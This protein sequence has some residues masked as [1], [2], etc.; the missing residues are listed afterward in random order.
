ML[1]FFLGPKLTQQQMTASG[2]IFVWYGLLKAE[3]SL[4]IRTCQYF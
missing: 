4:Y 2:I 1:P 3:N